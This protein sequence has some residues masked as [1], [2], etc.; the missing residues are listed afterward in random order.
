MNGKV[1]KAIRKEIYS[2][3]DYRDR[4]RF[5]IHKRTETAGTDRGRYQ[6]LKKAYKGVR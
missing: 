4:V 1:A 2:D 5:K 6:K 3:K